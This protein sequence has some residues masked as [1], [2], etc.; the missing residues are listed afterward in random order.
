VAEALNKV[1]RVLVVDDEI[2]KLFAN[3]EEKTQGTRPGVGAST[4][5]T[6]APSTVANSSITGSVAGDN[7]AGSMVDDFEDLQVEDSVMED[8][9]NEDMI[10]AD[11]AKWRRLK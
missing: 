6:A 3:L 10:E 7:I 4:I 1:Q 2:S 11:L 5:T 8:E 9:F